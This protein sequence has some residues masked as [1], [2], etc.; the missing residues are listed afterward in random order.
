MRCTLQLKGGKRKV[1]PSVLMHVQQEEEMGFPSPEVF[2]KYS[3]K[4]NS[5]RDAFCKD[6]DKLIKDGKKIA[7]YGASATSTTLMYHYK[8]G[9]YL[10]Y[11]VDDFKVKQN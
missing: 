10:E 1:N 11:L 8:M 6:I 9:D 3:E 4:I 7:G 5:A 2:K